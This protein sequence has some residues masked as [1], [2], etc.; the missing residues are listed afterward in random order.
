MGTGLLIVDVTEQAGDN[1]LVA[2]TPPPADILPRTLDMRRW[3]ATLFLALV[4]AAVQAHFIWS[5]PE[6]PGADR[7]TARLRHV[8]VRASEFESRKYMDVRY[9]APLVVQ[10]GKGTSSVGLEERDANKSGEEAEATKLLADARAARALWTDFPGFTAD[11]EV[12]LDGIVSRSKVVV[13]RD[14]KLVLDLGDRE[15]A[16]AASAWTR[17]ELGSLVGHRLDGG[18]DTRTPCA[19]ADTNLHHPLGRA[20]RVLNDEFHSSYRIRDRQILVV[21]RQ[22]PQAGVRFTIAVLANHHNAENQYLPESFVVNSWDLKTSALK[23]SEAHEQTWQRV[24][25]FDLPLTVTTVSATG[26]KQEARSLKLSNH[27]LLP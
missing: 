23:S 11:V 1:V 12:N 2:P 18:S 14:G 20:I 5:L 4:T 19:F 22:M 9:Y 6:R 27:K 8:E 25:K 7:T 16:K 26:E 24:G 10:V 21:N 15:E 3:H 17:R 13:K